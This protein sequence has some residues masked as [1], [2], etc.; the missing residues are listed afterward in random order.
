MLA[1][2]ATNAYP[3]GVA[4]EQVSQQELLDL[5]GQSQINTSAAFDEVIFPTK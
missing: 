5:N 3:Y 4:I 1:Y 2:G